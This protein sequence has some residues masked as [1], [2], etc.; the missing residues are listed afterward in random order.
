MAY[1]RRFIIDKI[2]EV[3]QEEENELI[4]HF[5]YF[6]LFCCSLYLINGLF[7]RLL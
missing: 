4:L 1:Y 6:V 2:N 5:L 3:S 7:I